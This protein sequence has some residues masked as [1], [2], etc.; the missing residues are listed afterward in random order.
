MKNGTRKK[1]NNV[2]ASR[3]SPD[4]RSEIEKRAYEIWLNEGGSHGSDVDHW[5]QAERELTVMPL[6]AER[7]TSA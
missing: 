3:E 4:L 7:E 1:G 6:S 2:P 5:L